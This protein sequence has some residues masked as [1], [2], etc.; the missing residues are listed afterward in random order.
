L[1]PARCD[2]NDD[3]VIGYANEKAGIA[4][5]QA[6]EILRSVKRITIDR[7]VP[8]PDPS[9]QMIQSGSKRG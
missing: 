2:D 6:R 3:R 8:P 4:F 7:H 1:V 9:I 5:R